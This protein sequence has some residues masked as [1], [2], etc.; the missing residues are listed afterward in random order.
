MKNPLDVM[1]EAA[2]LPAKVA[3]SRVFA[4]A[5]VLY[6]ARYRSLLAME[7][8]VSPKAI[9]AVLMG[10]HGDTMVPLPRYTTVAGI[11]V[12]EMISE[13][14]LNAIIARTKKGGG[15]IVNLLGTSA[16]YAP[17]AAAAQMVE[18]IVKDQKRIFPTCAWLNGEYGLKDMYL[19]VPVKLGINGIEE[20]IELDLNE[21]EKGLLYESAN[22]VREVMEVLDKMN[23]K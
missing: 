22:S 17:G 7:L 9:Q 6:T 23:L 18:A 14:K 10:G 21:Q 5:A 19:G 8:N 3:S 15:E 13:D 16:W 20:I 12:T 2:Y 4:M 1:T 11:P